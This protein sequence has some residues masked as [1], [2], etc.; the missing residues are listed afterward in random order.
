MARYKC[1]DDDDDDDDDD[2][3]RAFSYAGPSAWNVKYC[4]ASAKQS[5]LLVLGSVV[6][7]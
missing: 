2:D 6:W 1:L 3:E 4:R 5:I 7:F